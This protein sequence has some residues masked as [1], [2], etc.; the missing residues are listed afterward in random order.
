M[1]VFFCI[2]WQF[3]F[4]VMYIVRRDG[5]AAC[6]RTPCAVKTRRTCFFCGVIWH[7]TFFLF[8]PCKSFS[9][10]HVRTLKMGRADRALFLLRMTRVITCWCLTQAD[11]SFLWAVFRRV[12]KIA[13]RWWC[14]TVRLHGTSRLPLDGFWWNLIFGLFTKICREN[15]SLIK[16]DMNNGHFTWRH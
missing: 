16:S 9:Y 4:D 11:R 8:V 7:T 3:Y 13:K 5:I 6:Y 12:R 15:S 1:I 14:S 2:T 10:S